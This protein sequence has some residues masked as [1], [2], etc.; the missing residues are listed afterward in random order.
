MP[1][2]VIDLP[3]EQGATFRRTIVWTTKN[4]ADETV[5]VNVTGWGPARMQVRRQ[6]GSAVLIEL[7]SETGEN[8]KGGL[9]IGGVEGSIVIHMTP[10]Q[11]N[12]LTAKT[13]QYDLEINAPNGDR[14]RVSK[15]K[16]TVD[17]NITQDVPGD[18]AVEA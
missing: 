17:P 5:P 12:L 9:A 16:V 6:Q 10:A 13:A 14:F 1:A 11:T 7:D 8:A 18:P 4:E 15:G 2:T 3:V